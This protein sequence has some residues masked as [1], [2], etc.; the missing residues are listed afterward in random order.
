[1]NLPEGPK[2]RLLAVGLVIFTLAAVIASVAVPAY[3]LYVR[4]DEA[5]NTATERIDR[6]Q[7]VASQS[8]EHQKALDVLKS[9]ESSRFF[10][11][12]SAT[13]L[14][15]AELTDSVRPMIENNGAR[16]TSVGQI[17]VKDDSGFRL[18]ALPMGFSGTPAALQKT[19]FALET[20]IPYLFVDSVTFRATVPRGYKPPPN[21]EPEVTVQLEIQAYGPKDPA[22]SIKPASA[23]GAAGAN[24]QPSVAGA[25]KL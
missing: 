23:A 11:K 17:T 14:G 24:I 6:Y 21:Q 2:G 3:I 25:G 1:M 19:L 16:L 7:R 15:G 18:Y 13:N 5:I 10:L 8:A 22:R 9:R 4:Y 12:N 20:A